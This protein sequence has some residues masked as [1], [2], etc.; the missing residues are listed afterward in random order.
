MILK[1]SHALMV[2]A[3]AVIL[4][5]A[6]AQV[7][8][9]TSAEHGPASLT[10]TV[11]RG[12]V[13]YVSGNDLV[14][15][16]EDGTL[17]DFTVPDGATANVDGKQLGL[18]DLKPG[19]KLQRT[20]T[21]TTTPRVVTTVQT[22]KGKVFQVIPPLSVIL[23]LE[24]GT[25]QQFTIPK[26]QKFKIDGQMVDA[27][28]LK[29]GMIVSAT[30]VVESPETVVSQQRAVTGT[31]PP[32]PP[33]PPADVPILIA[34]APPP[35]PRPAQTPAA[36]P[37]PAPAPVAAA[38]EPAPAPAPAQAAEL[39]KTASSLPLIGLLGIVSL[40]LAAALRFARGRRA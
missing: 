2:A 20:I 30:K 29:R 27:F 4:T 34:M 23:T 8:T 33:A 9:S 21:T 37:A 13:V 6:R 24:D 7:Q 3:L 38:P 5:P 19:M 39:P 22:V 12:E 31:I 40:G 18:R 28:G 25:N 15:K 17:R 32:P 16:M 35:Q 26:N 1:S 10:T 11:E 36:R 14:V